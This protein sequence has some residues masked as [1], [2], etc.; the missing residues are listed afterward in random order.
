MPVGTLYV[1][2][3]LRV[4]S[5]SDSTMIRCPA[6]GAVEL[7][8]DVSPVS[9]RTKFL[10]QDRNLNT[11]GTENKL[12]VGPFDV[13]TY[14]TYRVW[15]MNKCSSGAHNFRDINIRVPDAIDVAD[16]LR[17]VTLCADCA[18][19][20]VLR[21]GIDRSMMVEYKWYYRQTNEGEAGVLVSQAD[22]LSIPNCTQNTG[23][24]Y[25][26]YFNRCES[27]TTETS[28]VRIDTVPVIR[29]ELQNDTLCEEMS[30]RVG[31]S[32][33]G[34]DLTYEW[35]VLF[36]DGRDSV[37]DRNVQV[38]QSSTDY[39]MWP[40]VTMALDSAQV[41]CRVYNS[42]GED[43]SDTMLLRVYPKRELEMTPS[44]VTICA[45]DT[46]TLSVTLVT[47]NPEWE[48]TVRFPD[49]SEKTVRGISSR[50][51]ELKVVQEGV[52]QIVSMKDVDGCMLNS[53][54]PKAEI[55]YNS[56][57]NL[58]MS[59]S[60]EVCQDD[61]VSIH[62]S[63]SGGVGPWKIKVVDILRGDLADEICGT[64]AL[65]MHGRDTVIRFPA[66]N[67]AEYSLNGVIDL[68][69]GCTLSLQDSNVVINVRVPDHI[70]FVA[71]PWL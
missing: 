16:P 18:T 28:W 32:A 11:L 70:S 50:T 63:I 39:G 17:N 38:P 8:I 27:K 6:D 24:Y 3:T 42:C 58:V 2:D 4:V 29:T 5:I 35:H 57:A 60:R 61:S 67:S 69:S 41:W 59:G 9:E 7:S 46:S 65:V 22:T 64:D 44:V 30:L 13:N 52:Y 31:L 48:Y 56:L 12:L 21:L 45:G 23:F 43:V 62:F 34:G 54:L 20:T 49:N 36:K 66:L 51:H 37:F 55:Q 10:W 53:G 15:F 19:D 14:H 68:G 71:G 40:V 26:H 25:C 47:G 33:T 1:D